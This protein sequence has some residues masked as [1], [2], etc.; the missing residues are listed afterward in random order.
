MAR[1]NLNPTELELLILQILWR[2]GPCTV[3]HVRDALAPTRDLARTSVD[4]LLRIMQR[5]GFVRKY[6]C[7]REVGGDVYRAVVSHQGTARKMIA[8]LVRDMFGGSARSLVQTLFD[9]GEVDERE[10]EELKNL[11]KRSRE[12]KP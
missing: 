8:Q 6:K 12:E 10:L 11:V 4:T 7:P 2:D 1:R 3:R 9:S 5:K